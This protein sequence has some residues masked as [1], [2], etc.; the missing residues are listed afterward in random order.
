LRAGS[1][2]DPPAP[3][4]HN[5][6]W[7]ASDYRPCA[8]VRGQ[9]CAGW[10][11]VGPFG[12]CLPHWWLR[13]GHRVPGRHAVAVALPKR[14]RAAAVVV[15]GCRRRSCGRTW[16][17]W[18]TAGPCWPAGGGYGHRRGALPSAPLPKHQERR[19]PIRHPEPQFHRGSYP[20]QPS[21]RS[22]VRSSRTWPTTIVGRSRTMCRPSRR[23]CWSSDPQW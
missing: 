16:P 11:R 12:H 18:L 8:K 5:P 2:L 1:W 10:A 19:W 23:A 9:W 17:P 20:R 21:A 22:S 7:A 14:T 15:R 13:S 6:T 4:R 3:V